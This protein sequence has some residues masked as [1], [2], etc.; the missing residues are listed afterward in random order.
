MGSFSLWQWLVVLIVVFGFLVPGLLA[1]WMIR[2]PPGGPGVSR[3]VGLGAEGVDEVHRR[4]GVLR[5]LA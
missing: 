4:N 2:R 5:D 3:R 1:A